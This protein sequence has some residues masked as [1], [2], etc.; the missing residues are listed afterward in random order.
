MAF[1]T[2]RFDLELSLS[3]RFAFLRIGR[4]EWC[5]YQDAPT[6]RLMLARD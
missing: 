4:R 6:G 3:A 5:I 1:K 2:L